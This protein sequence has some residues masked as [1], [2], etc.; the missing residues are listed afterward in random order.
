MDKMLRTLS[1]ATGEIASLTERL[2]P[3]NYWRL[4]A[5]GVHT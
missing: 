3:A 4:L 2:A 5:R 1:E